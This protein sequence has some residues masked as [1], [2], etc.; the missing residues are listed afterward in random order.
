MSTLFILLAVLAATAIFLLATGRF[1]VPHRHQ[2]RAYRRRI[3][4][5][6]L[7]MRSFLTD[8]VGTLT[9]ERF[10]DHK[11]D[12]VPMFEHFGVAS[13]TSLIK[14]QM[15]GRDA[16]GNL[17]PANAA[18]VAAVLGAMNHSVD[19][20]NPPAGFAKN[21]YGL[22]GAAGQ[23]SARVDYGVNCYD[24]DS[25]A[26]AITVAMLGQPCWVKDDHTVSALESAGL[27]AGIV[28]G[29]GDEKGAGDKQVQVLQGPHGVA[30]ATALALAQGESSSTAFTARNLVTSLQAYTGS[31]TGTLTETS[32]GAWAAQDGVTNVVGDIVFIQGGTTN[33]TA[34]ADAGPWQIQSLGGAS[35]K[36]VL[37]R[38]SWFQHGAVCPIG[39]I[40]DVGG[41]GTA[42]GATQW[43]SCAAVGS[44]VI[45]TN[46]L[47]FYVGR[48]TLQTTLASSAKTLSSVGVRSATETEVGF[49][50]TGSGAIA[51][52]VGYAL[53]GAMTAGYAGAA[54]IPIVAVASG[55]AKNG[56]TDASVVNVTVINW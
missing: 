37:V 20:T 41:E 42:W 55:M 8:A 50:Y 52:T 28:C 4:E 22:S 38:P 47:S 25:G 45:D 53:S 27:P 26:G 7:S 40:I 31:G 15:V 3:T 30:L 1:P 32:N 33:L 23:G 17:L 43:K 11:S 21:S 36:W 44:A 56:T 19:N 16:S 18:G 51:G 5:R 9:I 13:N 49:L 34:A 10:T 29:V 12:T 2:T 48:I 54:S 24:N 6:R 35:A 39:A 46:D 14:G